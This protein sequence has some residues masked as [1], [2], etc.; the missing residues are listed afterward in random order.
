MPRA[1]RGRPSEMTSESPL[2][3]PRLML[4][5][6]AEP[7]PFRC[8]YCFADFADYTRRPTLDDAIFCP[9]MLN[10]IEVVYPACDVDLF[11]RADAAAILERTVTLG[12]SISVS[13]KACLS[14]RHLR[15][16]VKAK[17][18]L[19]LVGH[20]IKVGVSVSTK[21]SVA[22]IEPGTP[23]YESRLRSLRAL[24][25]AGVP[26]ALVLRPLLA[27]IS[28][29]EYEEI[30][31]D[32]ANLSD[33]VLFG[34][35]WV[36]EVSERRNVAGADGAPETA[37]ERPRWLAEAPLWRKRTIPGRAEHLAACA[38]ALG[39]RAYHSDLPLMEHLI[40]EQRKRSR[41]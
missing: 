7:C 35:E 9:D 36:D 23:S 37:L 5:I 15:A 12:R 18:A 21:Y 17:A 1:E 8:S 22:L 29:R 4:S 10:A 16:L 24:G 38:G 2:V 31:K 13:T 30:L 39:Y 32:C 26:T 33:T 28:D 41:E 6:D 34:D 20:T 25:L 14:A 3:E 27:E 40:G 11:V 19:S